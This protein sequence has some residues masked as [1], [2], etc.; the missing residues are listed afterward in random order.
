[1]VLNHTSQK[2]HHARSFNDIKSLIEKSDFPKIVKFNSV[3]IFRRIG[4][5]EAKVHGTTINKIHFHEVGAID[6]IIDIVGGSLAI[7]FV[8]Y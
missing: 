2:S 3:E 5:V 8:R 7:A 6:S 1:M 4:K